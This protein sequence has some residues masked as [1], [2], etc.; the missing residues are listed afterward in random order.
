MSNLNSKEPLE[1]LLLHQRVIMG[2]GLSAAKKT[3][4]KSTIVKP[5]QHPPESGIVKKIIRCSVAWRFLPDA[6]EEAKK[7]RISET[8]NPSLTTCMLSQ[9]KGETLGMEIIRQM[10]EPID[11]IFMRLVVV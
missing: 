7:T 1:G 10:S 9:V 4:K 6:F 11:A 8:T 5:K 3:K 2:K